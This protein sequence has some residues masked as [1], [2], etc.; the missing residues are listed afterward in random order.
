MKCTHFTNVMNISSKQNVLIAI[1]AEG[2]CYIF[3]FND[4][5]RVSFVVCMMY[6]VYVHMHACMLGVVLLPFLTGGGSHIAIVCQA[7]H[8]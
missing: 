1:S 2:D 7:D 6:I 8:T 4:V 3:D 5:S